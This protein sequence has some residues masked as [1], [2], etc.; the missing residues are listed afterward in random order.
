MVLET[1]RIESSEIEKLRSRIGVDLRINR[2]NSKASRENI[3]KFVMALGDDNPLWINP[4]YARNTRYGSVIAPPSFL[5]SV[6]APSGALAGGLPGVHSFHGGTDWQFFKTIRVNTCISASAKLTDITEKKESKYGGRSV[7]AT[8]EVAYKDQDDALLAT[9]RGWSIRVEREAG[10]QRGKYSGIPPYRYTP[11]EINAMEKACLSEQPLG[12]KIRYW[13]DVKEGDELLPV[14]KG[15]LCFEDMEN[16]F[17]AAGGVTCYKPRIEQYRKHPAFFYRDP[18]THFPEPVSNVNLYDYVAQA[19]GIPRAYD[20]GAQ[21]IS[22]LGHLL[23][24]WMGDDGFLARLNVKLLLP[25]L[26]GDTQWCKGKVAR[27]Y[28]EDGNSLLDCDIWCENQR[29]ERTAGGTATVRLV[30]KRFL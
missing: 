3:S 6:L 10:R 2:F 8:V 15:P 19:V 14:V 16:F 18:N 30:T 4:H 20:L 11:D 27:K 28:T 22:W 5:H 13:D 26:F 25:N 9:A 1:A 23:T 24:N 12:G 21:R 7:I 17:A 29:G